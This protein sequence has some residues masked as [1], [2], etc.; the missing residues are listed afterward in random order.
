MTTITNTDRLERLLNVKQIAVF[1]AVALALAASCRAWFVMRDFTLDDALIYYRYIANCLAGRGL[2]YNEGERI[3]ALTSP[4]YTYISILVAFLFGNI[5]QTQIAIGSFF[6][7]LTSAMSVALLKDRVTPFILIFPPLMIATC[8]FYFITFG[9]ETTLFTFLILLCIWLYT[10]GKYDWL[11]TS[12]GFLLLTRGEGVFLIPAFIALHLRHKRPVPSWK[13]FVPPAMVL[14][15]CF[16]F[17][18]VYYH[19]LL[20]HT[21]GAKILHGK[22]G[23][24]GDWS[25]MREVIRSLLGTLG[26][27][28]L[29]YIILGICLVAGLYDCRRNAALSLL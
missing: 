21:L 3:N 2:V 27:D 5:L 12:L 28:F 17:N 25:F 18:M 15:A 19:G 24:F 1:L 23:I 20:P 6:L 10:A 11:P 16:S 22:S 4:L 29:V 13:C 14:F 8:P 9:M 7:F 26:H